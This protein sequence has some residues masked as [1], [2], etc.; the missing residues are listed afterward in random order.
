MRQRKDRRARRYPVRVELKEIN[1][2]PGA[3]N[4]LLD[5]SAMGAKLETG[6]AFVPG[7]PVEISFIFPEGEEEVRLAGRVV[8]SRPVI[9]QL[10]RYTLGIKLFQSLWELEFLARRWQNLQTK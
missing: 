9:G 4:F 5:L 3:G 6:T 8:W 10:S 1:G 2:K 7:T